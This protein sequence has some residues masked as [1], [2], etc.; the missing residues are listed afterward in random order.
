MWLTAMTGVKIVFFTEMCYGW[1]LL[2][3]D[4]DMLDGWHSTWKTCICQYSDS[5]INPLHVYSVYVWG[6]F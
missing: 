4:S 5:K 2:A 1:C 6:M 3:N